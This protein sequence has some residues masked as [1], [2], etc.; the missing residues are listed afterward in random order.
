MSGTPD[1]VMG[2]RVHY[3]NQVATFEVSLSRTDPGDLTR[4]SSCG[5]RH[6]CGTLFSREIGLIKLV[7]VQYEIMT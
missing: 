5:L 3:R 1:N 7:W 6:M 4:S 2:V